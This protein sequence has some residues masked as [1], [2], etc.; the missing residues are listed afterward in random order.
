MS[1]FSF[2]K[3]L[4]SRKPLPHPNGCGC[5]PCVILRYMA[6]EY[7][8]NKELIEQASKLNEMNFQ[9]YYESGKNVNIKLPEYPKTYRRFQ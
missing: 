9:D 4:F 2:I 7:E 8:A 1:I 5:H 3:S 6:R